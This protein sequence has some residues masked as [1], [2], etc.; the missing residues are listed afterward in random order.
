[1][2]TY[3]GNA[4]TQ[5]KA[6]DEAE[7]NLLEAYAILLKSFGGAN[8]NTQNCVQGLVELY[9]ARHATQPGRGYDSKAAEW[10]AKLEAK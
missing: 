3:L 7:A 5:L 8:R 10:K 9:D 2:L 1:M 4:R 6:F